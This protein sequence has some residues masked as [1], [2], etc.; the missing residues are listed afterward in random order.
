MWQRKAR[1]VFW[2]NPVLC[3]PVFPVS[4][5][6]LSGASTETRKRG[7]RFLFR[8]RVFRS[9]GSRNEAVAEPSHVR[10]GQ[11]PPEK[12]ESRRFC[13]DTGVRVLQEPQ[14]LKLKERK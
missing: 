6:A 12:D 9:W 10:T 8:R 3:V 7:T 13:E 2:H 5:R 14:D 11:F 4:V 1:I